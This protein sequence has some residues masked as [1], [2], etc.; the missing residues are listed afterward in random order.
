VLAQ[1]LMQIGEE[2]VIENL[3]EKRG[4]TEIQPPPAAGRKRG[5]ADKT[6]KAGS[7]ADGTE[8][9]PPPPKRARKDDEK[10]ADAKKMKEDQKATKKMEKLKKQ[11]EK[12]EHKMAMMT[13]AAEKQAELQ[14]ESHL[15]SH[16]K[17]EC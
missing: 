2:E 9:K 3:R 13:E 4:E 14:A 16:L 7:R 5:K 11:M 6:E 12:M 8:M 1:K 17:V 15:E 10:R